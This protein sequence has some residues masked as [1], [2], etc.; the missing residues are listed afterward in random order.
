MESRIEDVER[1]SPNTPLLA[2][3]DVGVGKGNMGERT[4]AG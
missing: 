4:L 3:K 1:V 2:A